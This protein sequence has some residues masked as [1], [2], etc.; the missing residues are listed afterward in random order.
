M[1]IRHFNLEDLDTMR[2]WLNKEAALNGQPL[3]NGMNLLKN[4]FFN[5]VLTIDHCLKEVAAF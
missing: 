2:R 4:Y 3:W 1:K 5:K